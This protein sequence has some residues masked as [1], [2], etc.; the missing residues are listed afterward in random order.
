MCGIVAA[1]GHVTRAECEQMLN[2]VAHRGPDDYGI[3]RVG[4]SWI[5]HRRLSI[6]DLTGGHQP[7]TNADKTLWMVA[8]GEIYN[9][10]SIRTQLGGHRFNSQSD[11]EVI[12]HLVETQG[13][14]ALVKLV[15]M[16]AFVISGTDGRIVA[17]RDK[18][19]I[20]PLYWARR[21]SDTFFA[22]EIK[23]FDANL[24]PYVQTFP[25]GHYWTPEEGLVAYDCIDAGIGR[26]R[27]TTVDHPS[28]DVL[29]EL[30]TV[31]K[32]A[33]K[34]RMMADVPVGV[35]LSGGLDSSLIAMLA[36]RLASADGRTIKSFAVGMDGSPDLLAARRVAE[37][38]GT[39]HYERIFTPAEAVSAVPKVI[40]AT[41]SFD[42]SLIQSAV[43][44][45][46]VAELAA[47]HVKVVLT[48]EG[49]DELFAGY[50]YHKAFSSRASLHKELVRTVG[51][52]HHLNLQRCDRTT[53]VHGLEARVPFLD[54]DVIEYAL[55]L[56]IQ[57]KLHGPDQTE[58]WILRR[59]FE[60]YLPDSLLWRQKEQFNDGSGMNSVLRDTFANTIGEGEFES[61]RGAI[62][63]AL[64]SREEMA[65]FRLFQSYFEGVNIAQV[66]GRSP[67]VFAIQ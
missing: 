57:W 7:L 34:R 23:S 4:S 29:N 6:V 30:R 2:K 21:G 3:E 16:F 45:Y 56:P 61:H 12:I 9:H 39:E 48:G 13:P 32:Q 38:L 63:P 44:N 43:A 62:S 60:G 37:Y 67:Q 50:R 33:V 51:E 31:L 18:M 20:K 42:P 49:S 25:P 41:E 1:H 24:R 53:M 11:N 40:E 8:N 35:F 59:A 55:S 19:G 52:L 36:S 10:K 17:A 65:Y 14:R 28:D 5:G 22:S 66:S 54:G 26:T 47:Q 15:G 58:K 64:A 27:K 46:F